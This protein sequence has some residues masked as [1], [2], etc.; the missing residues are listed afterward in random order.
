M[1]YKTAI[2]STLMI[3]IVLIFAGITNA[4]TYDAVAYYTYENDTVSAATIS[5]QTIN[6]NDGTKLGVG[7]PAQYGDGFYID[8]VDFDGVDDRINTAIN[9]DPTASAVTYFMVSEL[10]TIVPLSTEYL[11]LGFETSGA[12]DFKL[13]LIHI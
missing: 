2:T 10:A 9:L 4:T 3:I 12:Q 1:I 11:Q 8:A 6:G 5:D 13:S 7:E